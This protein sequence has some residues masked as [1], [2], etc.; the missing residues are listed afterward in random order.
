MVSS[1]KRGHSR[2]PLLT[3]AMTLE[4]PLWN[5]A[6]ARGVLS[7]NTGPS[8]ITTFRLKT[9]PRRQPAIKNTCSTISSSM[10]GRW[11]T[12][13]RSELKWLQ[14]IPHREELREKRS[15]H[16]IF[17]FDSAKR[18]II[19]TLTPGYMPSRRQKPQ[20]ACKTTHAF[21]FCSRSLPKG[22]P[23]ATSA[24]S[25]IKPQFAAWRTKVL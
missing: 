20:A 10:R 13:P 18:K 17:A 9:L 12:H 19:K 15:S 2:R 3:S 22:R 21:L 7:I 1:V 8:N 5:D 4:S 23:I 14:F 25:Y 6:K 16:N 24:C 11:R